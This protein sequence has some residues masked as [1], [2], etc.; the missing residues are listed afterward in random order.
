M[1]IDFDLF[2]SI[3]KVKKKHSNLYENQSSL[4]TLIIPDGAEIIGRISKIDELLQY[5][6]PNDKNAIVPPFISCYGKSGT[7]KSTI[8]EFVCQKLQEYGIFSGYCFVNL[9]KASTIFG[10]ANLILKQLGTKSLQN[11]NGIAGILENIQFAIETGITSRGNNNNNYERTKRAADDN[12]NK[13]KDCH[14]PRTK[15]N[16]GPELFVL[17]LDEYDV[18]FH[19]K[20]A[21]PSDFVYGLLTIEEELRKKGLLM[22]IVAISDKIAKDYRFDGRVLSRIGHQEVYFPPY[23]NEEIMQIL[24]NRASQGFSCPVEKEVLEYCAK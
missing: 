17:A 1:T 16:K 15:M 8:V 2:D 3:Q 23:S 14:R 10:C 5:L 13:D 21:N 18:I 7:G 22:S 19:D 24:S 9:R 4:D 11:A 6:V 12:N 20:R